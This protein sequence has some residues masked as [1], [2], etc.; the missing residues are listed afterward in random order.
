VEAG[1]GV[2]LQGRKLSAQ[3]DSRKTRSLTSSVSAA[4]SRSSFSQ[5]VSFI[6]SVPSCDR[7]KGG[8]GVECQT[9]HG[10][11]DNKYTVRTTGVGECEHAA[12]N[13]A[14]QTQSK[15]PADCCA[16]RFSFLIFQKRTIIAHLNIFV[17]VTN[18]RLPASCSFHHLSLQPNPGHAFR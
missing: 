10:S 14:W 1:E 13:V 18:I 4:A 5:A 6:P 7:G 12:N 9:G 8:L 11:R 3:E 2:Y 17:I 16:G 15:A